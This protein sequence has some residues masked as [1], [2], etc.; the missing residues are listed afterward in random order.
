[1]LLA[2]VFSNTAMAAANDGKGKVTVGWSTGTGGNI[3][4]AVRALA[5]T[6]ALPTDIHIDDNDDT[7]KAGV[8]N[9]AAPLAAGSSRNVLQFTYTAFEKVSNADPAEA[10]PT[11]LNPA[12][13]LVNGSDA[14]LTSTAVDSNDMPINMAGGRVRIAVPNGWKVSKKFLQVYDGALLIYSTDKD[15]KV[16]EHAMHKGRVSFT[17]DKYITVTL[18]AKW[19]PAER[20]GATPQA[21]AGLIGRELTIVFGDVTT[22]VP[23]MLDKTDDR[24]TTVSGVEDT[25]ATND[26]MYATNAFQASSSARNGTLIRFS[27]P[28][29]RVGNILGQ[30]TKDLGTDGIVDV[31]PTTGDAKDEGPWN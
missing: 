12:P 7:N 28:A 1:M 16:T 6:T 21:A 23:R 10:T 30:K 20:R 4:N 9:S 22:F 31:E 15:A 11:L 29:I 17:A 3:T 8:D 14:T 18:D 26:I 5:T 25:D 27:S 19:S 24:D 13:V 2:A